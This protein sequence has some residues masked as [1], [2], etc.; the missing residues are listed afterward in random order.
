[1][2]LGSEAACSG[3]EWALQEN[4]A[5]VAWSFTI[6]PPV[7]QNHFHC[8]LLARAATPNTP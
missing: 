2:A 5:E 4:Q 1:M 6:W 8:I 7:S 3:R